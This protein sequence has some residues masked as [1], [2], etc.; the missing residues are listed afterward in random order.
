MKQFRCVIMRG[1]TSKAACFRREDMPR[2]RERWD[3]FLLD[4]MGSPD[5]TQIDGIGGANSLTSKVAIIN[6]SARKDA[7]VDYL[8]A[9]VSLTAQK[10]A[11]NSNCGNISSA[12]GPFA[13]DEGM[14]NTDGQKARVRI[15]NVNTEKMIVSEF[16]L[17][18]GKAKREGTAEIPGVPGQAAP[19]WLSFY[20]PQGSM[21]DSVLPTGKPIDSIATSRG[22]LNISI[23]DAAAPLVFVLA[24]DIGLQGTELPEDFSTVQLAFLEEI[25][26]QAAELCGICP[27]DMASKQSP[28]V[29]KMT[30]LAPAADYTTLSGAAIDAGAMDFSARMLSMQKPHRALA[31]TGAVCMGA[32]AVTEGTLLQQLFPQA[33]TRLRIAHAGGVAEIEVGMGQDEL[34]Y[35]TVLRTA[36]RLMQGDIFTKKDY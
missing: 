15:F 35:V 11:W 14:V 30:V 12:V 18:Q 8:F 36:R 2:D 25:R 9:Q 34:E 33:G 27:A 23:V 32:A 20:E 6:P 26:S 17:E 24:S 3:D 1:G 10:V 5:S 22:P 31:I 13:V 4:V 29:P 19:L 21:F 16:E 28:A 7:D